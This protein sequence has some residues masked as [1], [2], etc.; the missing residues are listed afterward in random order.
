[1][2]SSA[3]RLGFVYRFISAFCGIFRYLATLNCLG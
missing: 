3:V 1:M 2:F